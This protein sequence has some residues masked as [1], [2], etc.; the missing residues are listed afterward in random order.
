[1]PRKASSLNNR[2]LSVHVLSDLVFQPGLIDF[3][4]SNALRR[5]PS[6]IEKKYPP[7]ANIGFPSAHEAAGVITASGFTV[8]MLDFVGRTTPIVVGVGLW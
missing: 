3:Q 4:H 1:L 8:A 7:L 6:T 2:C 5:D